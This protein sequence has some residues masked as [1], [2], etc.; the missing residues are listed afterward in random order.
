MCLLIY[1]IY[2]IS[3]VSK[4]KALEDI[5]IT[6]HELRLYHIDRDH[7]DRLQRDNIRLE[8]TNIKLCEELG[9]HLKEPE[10]MYVIVKSRQEAYMKYTGGHR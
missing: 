6:L 7:L 3:R 9:K 2:F 10:L 5:S 1:L 8:Y 4:L